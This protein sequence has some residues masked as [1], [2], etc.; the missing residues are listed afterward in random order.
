MNPFREMVLLSVDEY[1]T[2]RKQVLFNHPNENEPS[3][4][5]ELYEI[6]ERYGDSLPIDQRMK[7]ESEI[8]AKH[9]GNRS[10]QSDESKIPPSTAIVAPIHDL[11]GIHFTSFPKN[12]RTRA[13]QIYNHLKE[14]F[15]SS[16]KWN[17]LGQILNEKNEA[18]PGS[19]IVEL[20]DTVTNTRR[21]Q[22]QPKGLFEFQR[23]LTISNTPKNYLSLSGNRQM[24][25]HKQ[26]SEE[27]E[28]Q[29][30]SEW[31]NLS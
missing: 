12:S 8:I 26:S 5:K 25:V 23:L 13:T 31:L 3:M 18:I 15:K 29:S 2:L 21:G 19:S 28:F 1:K 30:P 17:E 4:Q 7:L 24:E 10:Q 20:I 16:P 27:D 14:F 6:K 11:F 9:T 22:R